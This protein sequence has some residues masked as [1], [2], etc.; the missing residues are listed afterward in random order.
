VTDPPDVFAELLALATPERLL[1]GPRATG[2]G[3]KVCV[4]DSGVERELLAERCRRRGREL[5]FLEGGLFTGARP[6]PL[7]YDGHQSTPHGTTVADI[8]LTLAPQ[9]RLYSADIVGPQGGGDV[10][11]LLNALHWAV[12]EWRCQVINL[13][14]GVTDQRLQP[15]RKQQ[16]HRA[17]EDAYFHDVLLIAAAHND[18]PLTQS[19]PALFTPP[20]LSVDR[21]S[22]EGPLEFA[23]RLRERVEFQAYSRGYFGPLASEPATSWAAPHLSG[24]AARLLSLR[25]GLKPFEVKTLLYWMSRR[26]G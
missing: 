17:V 26:P 6:D 1:L 7:P 5:A 21:G 19:Y 12:H 23:Y 4:I 11:A 9:V 25:P 14:L 16:L 10:Q 8:I 2:E 18:H 20:L 24:L 22:F 3:V 13:S 15:A